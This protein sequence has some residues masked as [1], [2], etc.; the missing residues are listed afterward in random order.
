[1]TLKQWFTKTNSD[2][3]Y[4]DYFFIYFS[5]YDIVRYNK[6]LA[7]YLFKRIGQKY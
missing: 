1:M 7:L 5:K 4:L 3:T 6:E 2:M